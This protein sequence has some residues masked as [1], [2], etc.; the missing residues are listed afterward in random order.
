MRLILL[1]FFLTVFS[2]ATGTENANLLDFD[3]RSLHEPAIHSLTMY[4]GKPLVMVF[5]QP[6]CNWCARQVRVIN[7]LRKQCNF[8]AIAVG[9]GG[10][11]MELRE[12]LRQLRPTFPAYQ[13]SPELIRAMGGVDATPVMLLGDADGHFLNWSRGYLADKELTSLLQAT[14]QIDC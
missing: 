6:D 12:E 7:S 2:P 13:A 10:T 14:G 9:T 1:C 8:E 3:L 11:R 5:F 4:E